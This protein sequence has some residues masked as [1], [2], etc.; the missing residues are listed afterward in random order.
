MLLISSSMFTVLPTP[1][2]P[3]RPTLPPLANGQIRSI[4][5][6]PVSSSSTDGDSSSNFG[7][8]WWI[9]A[10]LV[11]L[12]RA[13]FVDRT[14]EHVHDAAQRG[15]AHRHRDRR[16][17]CSVTF[18]P[19]RRPSEEP[20]RDGAHDAVAELLLDFER[21]ALFGQPCLVRCPRG[22]ARR[23]SWACASRGNSTSTTAPMHWTM[24][25]WL[26]VVLPGCSVSNSIALEC[27]RACLKP[28]PRRRRFRTV[29]W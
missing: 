2:P 23:R 16:C 19:R 25:P 27:R 5:L 11:G 8:G 7:A 15:R 24:V 18:M 26:M 17:R 22:R 9:G 21:Q 29:P 12:D 3:N 14:A 28:P 20:M 6:M 10:A 1:A 13:G 4:T